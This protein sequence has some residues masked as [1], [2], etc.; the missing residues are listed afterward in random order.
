MKN[1]LGIIEM[2]IIVAVIGIFAAIGVSSFSAFNERQA[3]ALDAEKALSALALARSQALSAKD[4]FSYGVH[5]EEKNFILFRGTSFS[6][7]DAANR[8]FPL[9]DG[10]RVAGV[11]LAG[12]GIEVKFSKLTGTTA[13]SGTITLALARDASVS[14]VLTVFATG[15]AQGTE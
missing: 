1:G 12:G 6:G 8:T 13:Q 3:L 7:G 15:V 5:F 2:V 9:A 10:V 14:K 4:G 11:T